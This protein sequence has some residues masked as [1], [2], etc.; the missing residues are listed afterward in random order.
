MRVWP[1]SATCP[2][3]LAAYL[4]LLTRVQRQVDHIEHVWCTRL[5]DLKGRSAPRDLSS[6]ITRCFGVLVS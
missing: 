2:L 5:P 4:G 6:V 1:V 3:G